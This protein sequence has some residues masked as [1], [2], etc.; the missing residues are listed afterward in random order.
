MSTVMYCFKLPKYKTWEFTKRLTEFYYKEGGLPSRF[1]GNGMS[2]EEAVDWLEK[3]GKDELEVDLQLFDYQKSYWIV[4]VLNSSYYFLNNWTKFEDI[5]KPCF[6]DDRVEVD[7]KDKKNKKVAEWIDQELPEKH[8]F[9]I[10]IISIEDLKI[11]L[12]ETRR[13]S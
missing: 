7:R 1:L 5:I 11:K 8:Y 2:Y 4:R 13:L 9:I 3:Y 12:Y 6:Y 10:P